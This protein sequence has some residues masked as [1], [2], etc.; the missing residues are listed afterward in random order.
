MSKI[1]CIYDAAGNTASY[2]GVFFDYNQRRRMS[3]VTTP[4]GTTN[5]IYDALGQLIEKSGA[6]A[7]LPP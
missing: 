2:T 4:G 1:N 5:Y 6:A 3:S 7:V